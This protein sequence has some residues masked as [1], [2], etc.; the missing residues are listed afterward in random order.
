MRK[1]MKL[2]ELGGYVFLEI[3]TLRFVLISLTG[4]DNIYPGC[5]SDV[6]VHFY[7]LSTDLNPD[8]GRTHGS[9]PELL[10]YLRNVVD[11]YD[12]RPHIVFNT[13]VVSA[14][15]NQERSKY[16]VTTKAAPKHDT[17]RVLQR[18]QIHEQLEKEHHQTISEVEVLVSALGILEVTR[19]PDIPGLGE[20]GGDMFH[21]GTW[22]HDVV[23]KGKRVAVVG[24]GTSGAQIVPAISEDPSVNVVNICRTPVWYFPLADHA[25]GAVT[26]WI[27]RNIP[28]C[29]RLH[30]CYHFLLSELLYLLV[31]SNSGFR[32]LLRMVMLLYMK[33]KA[34]KKYYK[35][36]VPKYSP[37]CKRLV[38]D[39]PQFLKSLHR[40]NVNMNWDGI[41]RITK[42]G[43][44]TKKGEH[45]PFDVIIFATGYIGDDYPLCV[46]GVCETVQE[47]YA[48]KGGPMAYCGTVLPGFPNFFMLGGP[49]TGTGHTSA[50]FTQETEIGYALNFIQL[51]LSGAITS[52]EVKNESTEEYNELIQR[53]LK[54]SVFVTC[55]SW[56]R[57]DNNGKISYIFPGSATRFW[58]GLRKVNWKH[59]N[60]TT[61]AGGGP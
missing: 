49:N 16:I 28:L 43:I 51:L 9:Q 3:L 4:K 6:A 17:S 31:F 12:L 45:L 44:L 7:S 24:N 19:Y 41:E 23:L 5:S 55:A 37:G 61:K 1:L 47:Y 42:D 35:S 11:K 40:P 53:R 46:K 39:R 22:N 33:F 15:W 59:F 21:S 14:V 25:Y 26:K 54:N 13:Q 29:L 34:P 50:Y 30:R 32:P 27:F 56:Y 36:I 60:V 48:R 18:E 58:W 20:F 10:E 57:K 52:F 8:W 2:V 38:M